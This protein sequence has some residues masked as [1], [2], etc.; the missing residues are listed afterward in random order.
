MQESDIPNAQ[1]ECRKLAAL[2]LFA[3][4]KFQFVVPISAF[5]GDGVLDVPC[6]NMLISLT[7]RA[8][9][10]DPGLR[11]VQEAGPYDLIFDRTTNLNLRNKAAADAAALKGAGNYSPNFSAA[12][13]SILRMG[14]L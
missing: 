14:R 3:L 4:Y 5:V 6:G 9:S 8:N 11:A 12:R 1:R 7:I 10:Q 2:P 13:F